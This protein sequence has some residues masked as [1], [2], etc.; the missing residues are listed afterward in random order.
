M[1]ST[2]KRKGKGKDIYVPLLIFCNFNFMYLEG[3]RGVDVTGLN[4]F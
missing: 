3:R 4:G 1:V 2:W